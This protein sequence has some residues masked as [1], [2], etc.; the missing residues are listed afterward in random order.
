MGLSPGAETLKDDC[1][2][3]RSRGDHPG[4]PCKSVAV[5]TQAG[6]DVNTFLILLKY[7]KS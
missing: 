7:G 1:G 5:P 6:S 2:F 4:A 3:S